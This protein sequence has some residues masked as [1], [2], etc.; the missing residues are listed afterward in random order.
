MGNVEIIIFENTV[1]AKEKN[2]KQP[3]QEPR[4]KIKPC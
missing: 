1:A 3:A 4:R 2:G